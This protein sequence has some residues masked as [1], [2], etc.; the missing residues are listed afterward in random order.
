MNTQFLFEITKYSQLLAR[1]K[2]KK[3]VIK[4]FMEYVIKIFPGKQ[5]YYFKMIKDNLAV[6]DSVSILDGLFTGNQPEVILTENSPLMSAFRTET[7][8]VYDQADEW[9]NKSY[10]YPSY[11]PESA[12]ALPVISKGKNRGLIVITHPRRKVYD[13]ILISLISMFYQYFL[14]VLETIN[15]FED[16]E[17]SNHTD[18]LTNLPN[19][20]GFY[21]Y[22]NEISAA[23]E[24]ETLS[25]IVLDLDHFKTIND[26]HGHIAGNDVLIQVANVL[27]QFSSN[28][29]FVAR[30]GGEEFILLAQNLSKK[31]AYQL[32]ENIRNV[33]ERIIFK[34]DYSIDTGAT[35]V[36]HATASFGLATYPD[37]VNDIHSLV[38]LA[39]RAMYLG[40]KQTG[41]NKITMHEAER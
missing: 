28:E 1:K 37:D 22:F 36:I 9:R 13:E 11:Y 32:T 39:D 16:L 40:S 31:E 26:K 35:A 3:A 14:N 15:E 30:F 29:V 41:R 4:D 6:L 34:I 10:Y 17:S 20:K 21:K 12:I 18:Y 8:T 5:V 19:L 33:I 24:Y 38:Q 7:V 2:N 25:L 27:M 23:E